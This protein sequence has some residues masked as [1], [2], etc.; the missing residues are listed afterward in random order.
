MPYKN[1]NPSQRRLFNQSKKDAL[2]GLLD[3]LDKVI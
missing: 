3:A 1:G 2:F